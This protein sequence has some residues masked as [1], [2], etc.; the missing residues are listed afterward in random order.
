MVIV[1]F[2]VVAAAFAVVDAIW[3]K[4]MNRFLPRPDW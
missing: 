4:T 2:L 3:L 1:Q